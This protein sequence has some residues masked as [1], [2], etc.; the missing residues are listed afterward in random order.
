MR[1]NK[2]KSPGFLLFD[3]DDAQQQW[4]ECFSTYLL[5]Y[6]S[7]VLQ[8]QRRKFIL[9]Q[10]IVQILLKHLED[11]TCVVLMLKALKRSYKVEL[12]GILLAKPRQDG[13]FDL[14]LAS[15]GWVVFE[16]FDGDNVAGSF[17]PAFYYLTKS[18]ATEKFK[19][20]KK[21]GNLSF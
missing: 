8:R 19:N 21:R 7:D 6:R 11:Q 10:E 17:F 13:D 1:E 2:I 9:L 4:N 18:T 16:D 14:A 3:A 5:Q 15:V 20:L 12:V